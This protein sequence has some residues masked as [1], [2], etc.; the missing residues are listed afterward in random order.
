MNVLIV[1]DSE[2]LRG[3]LQSILS[4]IPGIT[5]IG[6]A[7]DEADVIGRIDTLLP[8]AVI[9]DISMKNGAVIGM[10]ENIKKRY[11][12]IKIMILADCTNEFHFNRCLYT[13]EDNF[14]DKASQF[15]R[16]RA[17]LWQWVYACRLDSRFEALQI[18]EG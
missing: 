6:Y 5:V 1:E 15:M 10:L 17:A 3:H 16:I 8:D 4:D 14:F 7:A 13:G 12:G 2:T 18:S 9:F 11:S